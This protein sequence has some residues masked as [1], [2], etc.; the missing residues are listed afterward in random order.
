MAS[1]SLDRAIGLPSATL[2]VIG[3]IV[4]S[5][6]F[7]TTG[8][9]AAALPSPS[10]LLLAWL[11]GGLFALAGALTYAELGAMF[12]RAGG[13]Y[14]YLHEAFGA[15]PAFLYGWTM[16][17]VALCGGCAAVA[18]GFADYLSHFFPALGVDHLLFALP[19][20]G[21]VWKVSAG[22]LSAVASLVFL[23][24]VNYVGVRSG[25]GANAVLTAAKILGLA[26][27]PIVALVA[28]NVHPA[29]TPV[30]PAGVAS[31]AV[32]FG[33]AMIAVL[34]ANDG[35]Y[36][37]TYAA[38]EV[39][40]PARNLPRALILGLLGVIAIYLA[41]NLAYVV[42]LP[43]AELAGTSRVAERAATAMI[44]P[45]GATIVAL[46]VVVSTF[47]CNAA[48]I[49]ASSRL[50]YAMAADGLFFRSAGAIHPRFHSPHV[51]IVLVTVW[52]S[53]LALSGTYE[54]LF[55][56]VVFTSVLFSLFGGLA[57]F[58]LRRT[59]PGA[60]RPYRVWGYPLVPALFM[61]GSVFVIYNTL[62]QRPFESFAGLGLLAL[63]LP[64]Y[65]YWR[66][67]NGP[68]GRHA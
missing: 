18:V 34:W 66:S 33:V 3:G 38:G 14:I 44:G 13:V 7:L 25:S 21:V 48:A 52:S 35:Y 61:L 37:L 63:G 46:T 28:G 4:G 51:A 55:T 40:D 58:Q 39:R 2:L 11:A 67:S 30:V 50:L 54:Q 12:P 36:F 59:R 57:L 22:Q 62:R 5:G 8:I 24:A 16:L 45:S 31:P 43:M 42:A 65:A 9:M 60:L 68:G 47:G 10:L 15:L 53:L 6:I 64:V 56:Y 29:W 41:V 26:F 32:A 17:L 20:G 1:P 19:L 23:G 49:L 27:L